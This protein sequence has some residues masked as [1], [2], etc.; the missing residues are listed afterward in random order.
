MQIH[1][2]Q[3]KDI[4]SDILS[5][6]SIILFIPQES[7]FSFHWS[8]VELLGLVD[9]GEVRTVN[10]PPL[11]HIYS[12]PLLLHCAIGCAIISTT[13]VPILLCEQSLLL[14]LFGSVCTLRVSK[15]CYNGREAAPPTHSLMELYI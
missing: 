14:L 10:G 8:V 6:T 5:S 13:L 3:S 7:A 2:E 15:K 4:A 11:L 12:P 1:R 9:A